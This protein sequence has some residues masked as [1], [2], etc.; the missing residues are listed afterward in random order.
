MTKL[1]QEQIDALIAKIKKHP[2]KVLVEEVDLGP[3][4]GAP[5][6]AA[7]VEKTDVTLYETGSEVQASYLTKNNLK[8]TVNTRHVEEAMKLHSA[9]KKGDNVYASANS[10]QVS[11]VPITEDETAKSI[12]FPNA[13][14]EP[15]ME[16][17]PNEN[18]APH[19][20][21]LEFTC[22]PDATTG[23]PFKYK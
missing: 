7:D 1:T 6:I 4:D 12:T 10:K 11:L 19:S 17:T 22:K 20:V 18:D 23:V 13:F 14:L 9:Y 3:L 8:L 2:F 15:G 5:T 21:K 16:Y